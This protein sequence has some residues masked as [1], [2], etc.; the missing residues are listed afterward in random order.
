MKKLTLTFMILIIINLAYSKSEYFMNSKQKIELLKY[1]RVT[2]E[3]ELFNILICPG[4]LP[5]IESSFKNYKQSKTNLGEY[6]HQ[7]KY[8]DCKK[9]MKKSYKFAFKECLKEF[10]VEGAGKSWRKKFSKANIRVDKK[11]VGYLFAYP[12]A[13]FTSV[14]DNVVRIPIG[15]SGV[16]VGTTWATIIVPAHYS[17]NSLIKATWNFTFEGTFIPATQL[18]WNTG[19]TLPIALFSQRPST[20]RSDNFWVQHIANV[21]NDYIYAPEKV[22]NILWENVE[23]LDKKLKNYQSNNSQTAKI[24]AKIDSLKNVLKELRAEKKEIEEQN[25][26]AE[27][28]FILEQL[29]QNFNNPENKLSQCVIQEQQEKL[30]R[31]KVRNIDFEEDKKIRFMRI[32]GKIKKHNSIF[33]EEKNTDPVNETIKIIE[34]IE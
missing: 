19:V 32:F 10:T 4:Y 26:A 2:I 14:V 9:N 16:A 27:D 8:T 1:G 34:T 13:L 18:V 12:W 22:T 29:A 6:F 21:N 25:K 20:E 5:P 17:T 23:D 28:K 15:I 33:D 30:F 7:K 31:Q 24:D 3:Q 11:V